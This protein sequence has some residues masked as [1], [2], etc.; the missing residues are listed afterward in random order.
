MKLDED[1]LAW[2]EAGIITPEQREKILARYPKDTE[3]SSLAVLALLWAGGALV[4]LGIAF[5]MGISWEA[6]GHVRDAILIVADLAFFGGGALLRW[7]RPRLAGTALALLTIGALA[8]PLA[9]GVTFDDFFGSHGHYMGL[10][11]L[12]GLVDGAIAVATRSRLFC[13]LSCLALA[14][15]GQEVLRDQE[16]YAQVFPLVRM[17]WVRR[18]D[19]VFPVIFLTLAGVPLLAA[20]LAGRDARFAHLRTTLAVSGFFLGLGP[21]V[22]GGLVNDCRTFN[23]IL[24]LGAPIAGIVL[25]ILFRER[26]AFWV[27]MASLVGALLVFFGVVI[28][29]SVVVIL[30]AIPVGLAA[31]GVGTYLSVKK[32]TFLDR[33]FEHDALRKEEPV[34]RA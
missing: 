25:S 7:K 27:A 29:N 1:S 11:A 19:D 12:C 23:T 30:F 14:W 21:S 24:G 22:F 18:L 26:K 8:F 32:S 34:E 17:G 28:D 33:I 6:L 31:I 9:I 20:F 2:V 4:F 15:A 16:T 3:G 5:F 13:V 10:I